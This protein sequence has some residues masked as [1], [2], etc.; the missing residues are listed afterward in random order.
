MKKRSCFLSG[1]GNVF[2][3]LGFDEI[4]AQELT[5]RSF[6]LSKLQ[7]VLRDSKLTQANIGQ[8]LQIDQPRVSK[9]VKGEINKFSTDKLISYLLRLGYDISVGLNKTSNDKFGKVN[10]FESKTI[11]RSTNRRKASA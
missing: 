2:V 3:D 11:N 1:S 4:E 9:L 6:L 5:L 7:K 10:M 8:L